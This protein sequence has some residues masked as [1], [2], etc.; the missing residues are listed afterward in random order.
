MMKFDRP[1]EMRE[2]V[3]ASC[4]E[5]T[6]VSGNDFR[7]LCDPRFAEHRTFCSHCRRFD[8]LDAFHWSDTRETLTA[9]RSRLRALVPP[10]VRVAGSKWLFG[11]WILLAALTGF[12]LSKFIASF[13]IAYGIPAVIFF[14]IAMACDGLGKI[15]TQTI[16]FHQYQ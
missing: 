13:E 3:H 11:V 2:Y 15:S 6:P 9:Y 12:G 1:P 14:A 10:L 8:S 7:A 4:G 16:N 5:K